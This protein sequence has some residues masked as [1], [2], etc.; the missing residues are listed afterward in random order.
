MQVDEQK[1]LTTA[2]PDDEVSAFLEVNLELVEV[3]IIT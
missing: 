2:V 3:T 1:L